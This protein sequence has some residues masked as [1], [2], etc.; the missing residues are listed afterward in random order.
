MSSKQKN[1]AHQ[2]VK[3]LIIFIVV[4]FVALQVILSSLTSINEEK[5]SDEQVQAEK[6]FEE[7]ENAKEAENTV[8]LEKLNGMQERDR[9]EYY[10]SSFIKSIENKDYEK[11]YD[12]LYDEFKK[13]YFPDLNS[14]EEYA[15]KTFPKMATIE[16]TNIERSGETY[17]LFINISDALSPADTTKEMNVV[18]KENALNDF[19]MSFSVI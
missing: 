18:I 5:I 7:I 2:M 17:V 19:V 4:I 12:M 8:I 9:M 16:H 15:K 14:F 10:F 13:N 1:K 3:M 6:E 11:A